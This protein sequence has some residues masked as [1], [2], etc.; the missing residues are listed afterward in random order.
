MSQS[1][2]GQA[3]INVEQA[4]ELDKLRAAIL[5]VFAPEGVERFLRRLQKSAVGARDFEGVLERRLLEQA[6]EQL[7]NSGRTAKQLYQSL[8]AA[9]QGLVRELYLTTVEAVS[10][11]LREHFNKLYRYY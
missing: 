6:D 8:P 5:R 1:D 3:G 4:G 10:P 2:F 11:E 7:G 9:Q